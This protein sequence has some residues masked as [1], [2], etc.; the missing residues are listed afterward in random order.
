M[1][2]TRNRTRTVLTLAAVAMAGLVFTASANAA[3]ITINNAGFED[4]SGSGPRGNLTTPADWTEENPDQVYVDNNGLAW[5][6]EADRVLYLNAAGTAVNQDLSHNWSSSDS[7]TLGIIGHEAGWQTSSAGDAFSV[8]LRETDGT[9]LWDSGSQNVDGTV[10]GS[11]NNYSY[12][13][14]GHIFNWTIDASSFGGVSGAAAGSQFNIR[15]SRTGGNPYLDDVSL[16]VSTPEPEG[17]IPEPA[18]MALLGLAFAGLGGYVRKRR[19]I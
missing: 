3:A 8:E 11:Q 13:G 7:Y 15:I 5:K 17:E 18:T 9:V 4:A 14:T 6:P 1:K 10:T 16:S 12:T 2:T 19:S